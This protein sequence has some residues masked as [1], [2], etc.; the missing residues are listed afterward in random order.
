MIRRPPRPTLTY[1]LLPYTSRCRSDI[2][3]AH[4]FGRLQQPRL[5]GV[6][7]RHHQAVLGIGVVQL[8]EMARGFT[9]GQAV[10]IRVVGLG[11]WVVLVDVVDFE[12]VRRLAEHEALQSSSLMFRDRKSTRLNSSH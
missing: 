6:G 9:L 10:D 11:G 4:D 8:D 12:G 5:V 7:L 2:G 1:T 3:D